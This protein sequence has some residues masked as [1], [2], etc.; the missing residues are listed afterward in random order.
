MHF[1][2]LGIVFADSLARDPDLITSVRYLARDKK[3]PTAKAV[4][5]LLTKWGLIEKGH[6]LDPD[7]NLAQ[8]V[9]VVTQVGTCPKY[10]SNC[11]FMLIT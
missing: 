10:T 9:F 5:G 2:I 7:S 4:K 6:E 8:A 1:S 11:F 3:N